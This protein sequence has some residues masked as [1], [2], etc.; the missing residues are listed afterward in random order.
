MRTKIIALLFVI[1]FTPLL[2]SMPFSSPDPALTT[3][4]QQMNQINQMDQRNKLD[5]INRKVSEMKSNQDFEEMERIGQGNGSTYKDPNQ[6]QVE[7]ARRQDQAN[8]SAA[9]ASDAAQ[10]K[11]DYAALA[12]KYNALVARNKADYATQTKKYNTLVAHNNALVGKYN[13][14]VKAYRK[15]SSD[16]NK[17]VKKLSGKLMAI[18]DYP[19]LARPDSKIR[20][21]YEILT[22]ALG[23]HSTSQ[24][25]VDL[26]KEAAKMVV[27]DKG[28]TVVHTYHD[29]KSTYAVHAN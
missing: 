24:T 14:L 7:I 2:H 27:D 25:E 17:L 18:R 9:N 8:A 19:D 21:A 10:Y 3:L 13:T 12:K 22:N 16:G 4:D 6:E 29:A 23:S 1:G 20:Q 26:A 5:E 15:M 28:C 11:A